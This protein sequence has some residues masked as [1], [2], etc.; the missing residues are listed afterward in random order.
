MSACASCTG[1]LWGKKLLEGSRLTA[2]ALAFLQAIAPLARAPPGSP[3]DGAQSASEARGHH[4]TSPAALHASRTTRAEATKPPVPR[5]PARQERRSGP[6]AGSPGTARRGKRLRCPHN[7]RGAAETVR[8]AFSSRRIASMMRLVARAIAQLVAPLA[9]MICAAAPRHIGKDFRAHCAVVSARPPS[10][11]NARTGTLP[12]CAW[13][14]AQLALAMLSHDLGVHVSSRDSK[15]LGQQ[16]DQPGAVENCSRPQ[17][18]PR[19]RPGGAAWPR[20]STRPRG[21][22]QRAA[23]PAGLPRPARARVGGRD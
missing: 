19:P 4:Q 3:A 14:R 18:P 15:P 8:I 1:A 6:P 16:A 7:P 5:R 10:V 12:T 13:T 9:A 21:S 23:G 2:G 11:S 22:T 20:K 17:N